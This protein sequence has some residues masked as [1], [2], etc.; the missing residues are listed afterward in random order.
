MMTKKE[1]EFAKAIAQA[2][3]EAMKATSET[4]KTAKGRGTANEGKK[5]ETLKTKYSTDIKDY[6]PKKN[7]KFYNWASYK[8]NRTKFCYATAT[9]GKAVGCFENGKRVCTFE[10]IEDKYEAAKKLFEKKYKYVKLENR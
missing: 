3:V 6:E 10:E 8:S 1:L 9:S 2:V 7:G 4:P 5:T